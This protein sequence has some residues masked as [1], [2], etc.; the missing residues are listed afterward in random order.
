MQLAL[1]NCR[2]LM[3]VQELD[4]IFNRDNVV[5][6]GFIN[7]IDDGCERRTLA[8][9]GG[10]SDQHDTGLHLDDLAQLLRQTKVFE[11]RRPRRNNPHHN[12]IGAALSEDVDAKSVYPG[13]SEERR[14]GKEC[15]SRWSPYH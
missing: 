8:A 10:T 14:V 11:A 1:M 5:V 3:T 7:Q 2:I 13:R 15:R 9:A 4:R 6:L 12:C